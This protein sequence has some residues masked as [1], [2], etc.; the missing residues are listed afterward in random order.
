[1][2]RDAGE[3]AAPVTPGGSC[4]ALE[5]QPARRLAVDLLLLLDVSS[6]MADL[7]AGGTQSKWDIVRA[8]LLAFLSDPRSN[9]VQVGLQFF[10]LAGS[11]A[12][13]DFEKLAVNFVD[14]PTVLPALRAALGAQTNVRMNF[15]TPTGVALAAA[16]EV[17][18]LRVR[19]LPDRRAALV[20]LTDGEPSSCTP[21]A[22]D[23]VAAPVGEGRAM[24]PS[25]ATYV[26]GVFSPAELARAR[27]PVE[28]L[29]LVGGTRA[30]VLEAGADLPARL[31]QTLDEIR[32]RAVS[33]EFAIPQPRVQS[34]DYRRLNLRL[35]T[36]AGV[37]QPPYV[38]AADHCTGKGGWYFDFDPTIGAK[39]GRLITC[40]ATCRAF[41]AD[42]APQMEVLFG[43]PTSALP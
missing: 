4:S 43:C 28:T 9:G 12:L 27:D 1:M 41:L 36:V 42:P 17:L 33:C 34:L 5:A 7:V 3:P 2:G 35:T 13:A 8:G 26:I 38:R 24:N 16:H 25:V 19:A 23:E 15:G 29:A 6:S 31:A 20:L 11:C 32:T 10:P 30:F 39:P 18:R 40:A 37:E 14:L 21:L 22:I